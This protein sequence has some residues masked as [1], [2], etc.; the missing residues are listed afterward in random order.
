M[1]VLDVH[2]QRVLW[3]VAVQRRAGL[4]L[5]KITERLREMQSKDWADLPDI[6]AEWGQADQS[7]PVPYA[8]Q[9]AYG[10]AELATLQTELR[11][12]QEALT[13]ARQKV[14]T[15]ESEIVSLRESSAVTQAELQQQLHAAQ[16]ELSQSRGEV[17][18]LHARLD[19]FTLAYGMGRDKPIPVA[20]VVGV[21]ALVAVAVVV[22]VF[23]VARLLL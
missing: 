6:P 23:V 21:T 7:I 17:D 1:R 19:A 11:Y 13:E 3:Y 9:A 15:L 16:L 22:L 14:E 2:D 10:M 8:A 12:A 5:D 4:E 18:T 20:L